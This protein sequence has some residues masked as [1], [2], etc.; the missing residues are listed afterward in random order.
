MSITIYS[1]EVLM[2]C[3]MDVLDYLQL[4]CDNNL[5]TYQINDFSCMQ[6]T[7][8]FRGRCSL[9]RNNISFSHNKIM[10]KADIL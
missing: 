8:S 7:S 5:K 9:I 4:C 6:K 2:H 1:D 3:S 10:L